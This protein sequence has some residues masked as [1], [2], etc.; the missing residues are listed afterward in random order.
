MAEIQLKDPEDELSRTFANI[1]GLHRTSLAR[2]QAAVAVGSCKTNGDCPDN[3]HCG[4]DG[5]GGKKCLPGPF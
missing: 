5:N 1:A 3:W 2:L 4:S